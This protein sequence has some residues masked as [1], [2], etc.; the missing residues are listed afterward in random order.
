MS[1]STTAR[2]RVIRNLATRTR[3]ALENHVELNPHLF[4]H[5]SQIEREYVIRL[6]EDVSQPECSPDCQ[7]VL[8]AAEAAGGRSYMILRG[9]VLRE[10]EDQLNIRR[11]WW[12]NS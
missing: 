2:E 4:T 6:F 9:K 8:D 12:S 10:I 3:Q 11:N 1:N 7:A 5:A